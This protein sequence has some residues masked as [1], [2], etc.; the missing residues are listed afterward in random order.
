MRWLTTCFP[1]GLVLATSNVK[2]EKQMAGYEISWTGDQVK[3]LVDQAVS[4]SR[5]AVALPGAK[6]LLSLLK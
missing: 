1:S 4:S 2:E 6:A 5:N 3:G